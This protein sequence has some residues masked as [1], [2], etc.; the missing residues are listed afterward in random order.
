MRRS[1]WKRYLRW[2]RGERR[3]EHH[4]SSIRAGDEGAEAPRLHL[5][6]SPSCDCPIILGHSD[7]AEKALTFQFEGSGSKGAVRGEWKC[8]V[9]AEVSNAELID[10]PWLTGE[11]HS[12]SQSCVKDVDLDINPDSPYNPKRQL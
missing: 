9:L 12:Q 10:G 11:R 8:L 3:A 2:T 6:R 5:P 4:L 1:A 7:G